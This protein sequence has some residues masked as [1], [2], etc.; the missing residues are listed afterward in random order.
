[1]TSTLLAQS[2]GCN[3]VVIRNIL[4]ALKKAGM[5][6]VARGPGGAELLKEPSEI[7]LYMIYD[8]MEPEGLSSLIGIHSCEDRKC[9]VAKNIRFVLQDPYQKIEDS[10]RQTM[11]GITLESMIEEFHKRVD[12]AD[13]Q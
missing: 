9:P 1:M 11:E 8:A 12:P 6:S 5:I 7:T 13:L 2:T 3:P 10:I 4:S